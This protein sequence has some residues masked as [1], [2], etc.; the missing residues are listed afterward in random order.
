MSSPKMPSSTTAAAPLI[1]TSAKDNQSSIDAMAQQRKKQQAAF[2]FNDTLIA[3]SGLPTT[4]TAA[5]KLLG[6]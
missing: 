2:S 6:L 3:Q 1:G 4:E 5:K